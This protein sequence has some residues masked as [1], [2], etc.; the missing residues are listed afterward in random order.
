MR[1]VFRQGL[2]QTEGLIGSILELLGLDL[3]VPDH[4]PI[5][6][7]AC[8]V[9]LPAGS[10]RMNGPLHRRDDAA[11]VAALPD[12]IQGPMA[13]FTGD[14][15]YDRPTFVYAAVHIGRFKQVIGDRLRF[16]RTDARA[17]EVAIAVAVLN[18]MLDF[19]RPNSVRAP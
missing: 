17:T 9:T 16:H 6:R 18:R 5:G 19:G 3:P 12:Q 13:L 10:G 1:T 11:E 7:R 8:T 4:S 15:A 2:R 14:G